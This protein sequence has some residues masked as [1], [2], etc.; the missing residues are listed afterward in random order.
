[1][2]CPPG[3]PPPN[4]ISQAGLTLV[5]EQK[6]SFIL[7][8]NRSDSLEELVIDTRS[9]KESIEVLRVG[10]PNSNPHSQ[11]AVLQTF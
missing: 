5:P 11:E 6:K 2:I 9:L 1:V 10:V 7:Q 4:D 8:T 3:F